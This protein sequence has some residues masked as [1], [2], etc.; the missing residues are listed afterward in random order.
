MSRKNKVEPLES[1]TA[2]KTGYSPVSPGNYPTEREMSTSY[3]MM[4][5]LFDTIGYAVFAYRTDVVTKNMVFTEAT[6]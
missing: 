3:L 6:Y 5:I 1:Y 2:S 4:T